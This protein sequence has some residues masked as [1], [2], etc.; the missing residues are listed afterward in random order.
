MPAVDQVPRVQ[1]SA[2]DRASFVTSYDLPG[3]PVV[4]AGA[5]MGLRSAPAWLILGCHAVTW[6][7]TAKEAAAACGLCN[8]V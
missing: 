5:H 4:I 6:L 2:L 7:L 1:H 8:E 3:L